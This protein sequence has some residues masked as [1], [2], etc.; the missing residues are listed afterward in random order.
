[1]S[2][3]RDAAGLQHHGERAVLETWHQPMKEERVASIVA[4]QTVMNIMGVPSMEKSEHTLPRIM[5]LKPA[6]AKIKREPVRHGCGGTTGR[7]P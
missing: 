6:A 2:E 5:K 1:M 4:Q 3:L 7:T